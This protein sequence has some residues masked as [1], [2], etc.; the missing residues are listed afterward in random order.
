MPE[1]IIMHIDLDAFFAAVEVRE[2][3]ELKGKPVV[4]GADPM[5]GRGRG[6]V[7]TCSYEARK[8]G[9]HS[10][11]PISRAYKLC[12]TAVFLPVNMELYQQ[13]SIEI[14]NIL[15]RF[16]DKMEQVSIDEAYLDISNKVKDYPE[17]EQLAKLIKKA[18][19]SE[20]RLTCSIGIG[21]NK[22]IAKI[23]SDFKKP[24]G[25]TIVKPD[26]VKYFLSNLPVRKLPGIGPKTEAELKKLGINTIGELASFPMQKLF[27][28]F[29]KYGIFTHMLANGIDESEVEQNYGIKSMNRQLTFAEDTGDIDLLNK[30]MGHLAEE[31]H[32]ELV[33]SNLMLK[34]VGIRVRYEDFET[35]TAEKS[36]KF[37]VNDVALIKKTSKELLKQF[38][39]HKRIRLI[40]VRIANLEKGKQ[41]TIS[42][43]S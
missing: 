32:A 30:V 2:N 21:P 26:E 10:A 27:D 20:Q 31:L 18:I 25:L 40:G 41:A 42:Q 15:R 36:F 22:T 29:G 35:H 33:A 43:Y 23:A 4:I 34:T 7:S 9:I 3:P 24:D 16:A 12:P 6:V 8:F 39:G 11:M 28:I 19:L 38:M 5:Q 17:A 13:A 1:R 37:A 14:M